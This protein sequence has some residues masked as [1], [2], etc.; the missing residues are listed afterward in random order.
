MTSRQSLASGCRQENL[1]AAAAAAGAGAYANAHEMQSD[2]LGKLDL[3]QHFPVLGRI[4]VY[5]NTRE[6][7][8]HRNH[9]VTYRAGA[10]SV[11]RL[12]RAVCRVSVGLAKAT[13][14]S[15]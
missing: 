11:Q 4:G 2:K 14:L 1:K 13:T 7:I 10:G 15:R 5:D 6:L 8:V 9:L 12:R 3:L